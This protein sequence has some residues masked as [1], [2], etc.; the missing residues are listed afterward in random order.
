MY[1]RI[2]SLESLAHVD[3]REKDSTD[4]FDL[5]KYFA[6]KENTTDEHQNRI[7]ECEFSALLDDFETT[8]GRIHSKTAILTFWQQQ[9]S[10]FPELYKIACVINAI[11]PAQ[12]TVER[13]FSALKF[14]YGCLRCNISLELLRDLMTIRLNKGLVAAI[15]EN[16]III[17]K[18]KYSSM[19]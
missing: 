4:E 10:S 3:S 9:K 18:L 16:D 12:A 14:V 7:T 13:C 6:A 15:F 1:T 8:F 19:N 11:P 5:E 2:C 17:E